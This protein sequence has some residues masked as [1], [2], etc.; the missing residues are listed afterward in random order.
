MEIVQEVILVILHTYNKRI[1]YFIRVQR[2]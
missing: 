1:I 2:N